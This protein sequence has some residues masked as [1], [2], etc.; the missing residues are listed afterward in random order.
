M[1]ETT[2]EPVENDYAKKAKFNIVDLKKAYK[3]RDL[4][5]LGELTMYQFAAKHFRGSKPIVPNFTGMET[6]ATWPLTEPFSKAML[7][8]HHP[9]VE[10]VQEVLEQEGRTYT[11]Y[12]DR[13]AD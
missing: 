7:M 11:T 13:L 8:L 9:W 1:E 5:R 3:K 2:G 6:K 4:E 10:K 12:A